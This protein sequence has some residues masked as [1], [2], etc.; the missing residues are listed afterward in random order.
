MTVIVKIKCID[1]I[2][3]N[4][5]LDDIYKMETF[6]LKNMLEDTYNNEDIIQFDLN[7]EYDIVKNILD[8]LRYRSLI[9][10]K[11]TNLLLMNQVCDKWCVPF[12]L[13]TDLQDKINGNNSL[14]QIL[15]F[16]NKFKGDT[17]YCQ[18]CNTGFKESLNKIDSCKTH[19]RNCTIIGS[20][21]YGCCN[22]EEPC[23]VGYHISEQISYES[24]IYSIKDLVK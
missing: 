17:K 4:Y 14:N 23:K 15:Y 12:W 19:L 24:I 13:L 18:I 9:F 8:S 16:M 22:K 21:R 5:N 20:D 10:N 6:Y 1:D 2:I 3:C 7:E 11:D